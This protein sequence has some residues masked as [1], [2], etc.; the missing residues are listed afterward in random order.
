MS[1]MISYVPSFASRWCR[2]S[3]YPPEQVNGHWSL[4]M[5]EDGHN[6]EGDHESESYDDDQVITESESLSNKKV[7]I[8]SVT[9]VSASM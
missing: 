2:V 6:R 9:P 4:V 7:V 8:V 5:R 3:N 1:V